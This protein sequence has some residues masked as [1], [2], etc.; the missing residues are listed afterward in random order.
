MTTKSRVGAAATCD[1]FN[2]ITHPSHK[3][4]T[5]GQVQGKTKMH[6]PRPGGVTK[7]S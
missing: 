3:Q 6:Y 7:E 1:Q 4:V 2:N 5:M